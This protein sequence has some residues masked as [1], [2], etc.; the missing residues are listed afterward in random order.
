[1]IIISARKCEFDGTNRQTGAVE[2]IS[3]YKCYGVSDKWNTEYGVH[4]DDFNIGIEKATKIGI[5]DL[6]DN[7][8]PVRLLYNRYGKVEEIIKE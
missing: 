2:K 1:M 5:F 6:I 3:F 7:R 4:V 8:T